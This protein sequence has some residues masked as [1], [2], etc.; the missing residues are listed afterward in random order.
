[1]NHD[2]AELRDEGHGVPPRAL[3]LSLLALA[4]PVLGATIA[5]EWLS[6]DRGIVLWLTAL[7][8]P[9]LL[10]YYRGWRGASLG[11]A[12]GMAVLVLAHLGIVASGAAAPSY[13]VLLWVTGTYIAVC[14]GAGVLAELL[15]RERAVAEE[16]ALTDALT[17]LPNRRH[18]TIFLDT[19]FAAAIR[20]QPTCV[21]LFDLDRFKGV[22]D[23]HGHR[24]GD[25]VL[26]RFGK[27]LATGTRR[28]NLS[29]RWGGEEFISI[30]S[31]ADPEGAAVFA[32]RIR[33]RLREEEFEWGRIT[34]SAGIASYSPTMGSPEVLVA[35]ADQALYAAKEAGRDR[36]RIA[37]AEKPPAGTRSDSG[38]RPGPES[39]E[40]GE[41]PGEADRRSGRTAGEGDFKALPRG[42]ERILVVD[43][44]EPVRRGVT[45]F[46]KKLGYEVLNAPDGRRALE[47]ERGSGKTDLLVVD[48]IMPEMM[49]FTLGERFEEEFGPQRILYIS[50]H[51]QGEV[52]W[53][54][55]PGSAVD[56]I[57]KPMSAAA[58]A[59]K[60][61]VLLDR[62][63]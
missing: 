51:V 9:F 21:V 59:E 47:A 35:T 26:R 50:G 54:W 19:A 39:G 27:I 46:L 37:G 48:L 53:K 14:V 17:G 13:A 12:F 55:A 32:T 31:Q 36:Y 25:E 28:M 22:N 40:V 1:M 56:F 52:D 8:P 2:F 30:L 20:G 60:V 6:G 63:P 3:V 62:T 57:A 38:F 5:P 43:D 10:T 34:V 61:R 33:E 24:A 7:I 16:L 45:A 58:L 42:I 49:G 4:I 23:R 15:R 29:A 18:A 11:L 44:D 41:T